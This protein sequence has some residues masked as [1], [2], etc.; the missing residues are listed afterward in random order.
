MKRKEECIGQ[1]ICSTI[2]T[3]FDNVIKY[4]RWL[5]HEQS[6]KSLTKNFGTTNEFIVETYSFC[7]KRC[8]W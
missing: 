4:T 2:V 8:T 7:N 3:L 5:L 1:L 6:Q